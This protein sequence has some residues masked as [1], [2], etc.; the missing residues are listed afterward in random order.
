MP[1]SLLLR[2]LNS[3]LFVVAKIAI[4]VISFETNNKYFRFALLTKH[5]RL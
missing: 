4:T 1:F 3:L 5:Y 2:N